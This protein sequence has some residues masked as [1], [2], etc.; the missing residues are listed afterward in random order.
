MTDRPGDRAPRGPL[1]PRPRMVGTRTCRCSIRAGRRTSPR[2]P[3]SQTLRRAFSDALVAGD[4]SAAETAVRAALRLGLSP[5]QID[6]E[7]IAPALW[8]VGELWER[9]EITVAD[10]HLATEITVRVLVLQ[11]ELMRAERRRPAPPGPARGAGG[12]A[13]R[14][15]A[16]HGRRP[17]LRR[18]LRHALPR[19]RRAARRARRC[20]RAPHARRR[21][22]EHDDARHRA[23]P[24]AHRRPAR[25]GPAGR[26]AA[27]RR[28]RRR[29]GPP[30]AARASWRAAS[31]PRSS[32]RSTGSS[33]APAST[34]GSPH[35]PIRRLLPARALPGSADA[36]DPTRRIACAPHRSR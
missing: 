8:L 13:P 35:G 1:E 22:R 30:G 19:R 14:G 28:P 36:P 32:A 25:G 9:G 21:L 7:L 29:R 5:G 26:D 15:R 12:R 3:R 24:V 17:P 34:R 6:V 23:A 11:R 33:R 2:W 31:S 18:G 16:P 10:E 4:E 20:G 27:R